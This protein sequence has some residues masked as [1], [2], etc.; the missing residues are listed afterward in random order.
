MCGIGS[1]QLAQNYTNFSTKQRAFRRHADQ[2]FVPVLI[3]RQVHY[4]TFTLANEAGFFVI[5]MKVQPIL[6]HSD[7]SPKA[8]EEVR[9]ELGYDLLQTEGPHKL[10]TDAL[11]DT[12]PKRALSIARHWQ[13]VAPRLNLSTLQVLRNPSTNISV[14]SIELA[15]LRRMVTLPERSQVV[16]NEGEEDILAPWEDD[17]ISF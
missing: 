5:P 10:I 3:A 13:Q 6:P 1:I 17:D 16:F 4:T 9:M 12:I 8:V 15:S 2:L 14:R 7:V 11:L